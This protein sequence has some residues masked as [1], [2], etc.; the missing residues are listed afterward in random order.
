MIRFADQDEFGMSGRALLPA[1]DDCIKVPAALNIVSGDPE[2]APSWHRRRDFDMFD[3]MKQ[4]A[5]KAMPTVGMATS[6]HASKQHLRQTRQR[7]WTRCQRE[8]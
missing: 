3:V 5:I 2:I 6:Y 7:S 8:T 4:R 1:L